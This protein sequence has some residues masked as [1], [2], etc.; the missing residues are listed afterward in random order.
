MLLSFSNKQ[1]TL[2]RTSMGCKAMS[3]DVVQPFQVLQSLPFPSAP[4]QPITC[5]PRPVCFSSTPEMSRGCT[6]SC[7]VGTQQR[8][9]L[10]RVTQR[11]E[12]MMRRKLKVVNARREDVAGRH[13]WEVGGSRH[14][15]GPSASTSTI[16]MPIGLFRPPALLS[17]RGNVKKRPRHWLCDLHLA[18]RLMT[19]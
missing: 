10:R 14:G 4:A 11:L 12:M 8:P 9:F 1:P 16:S 17:S 2:V 3:D 7:A 18:Y 6:H 13:Q 15:F 5:F 19:V